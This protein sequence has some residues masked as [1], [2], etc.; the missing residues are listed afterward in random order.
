MLHTLLAFGWFAVVSAGLLVRPDAGILSTATV[1][2]GLLLL[3]DLFRRRLVAT[4][5]LA[6]F[7]LYGLVPVWAMQM[8]GGVPLS[9]WR[10]E[11]F[12][13]EALDGAV[14]YY[15]VG[16]AV[17]SLGA[18]L[19]QRVWQAVIRLPPVSASDGCPGRARPGRHWSRVSSPSSR[20]RS[21]PV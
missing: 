15:C 1:C 19:G 9:N 12:A 5:L 10:G 3:A 13:P 18:M 11:L 8:I 14:R 7:L 20:P 6:L 21:S 4:L 17:F 16:F 2:L